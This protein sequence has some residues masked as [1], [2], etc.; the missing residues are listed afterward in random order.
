MNDKH[1]SN[2]QTLAYTNRKGAT[3]YLHEGRTKSGK[4][5][6]FFARSIGEGSLGEL[7]T[8]YEVTETMN[9][10]VSVRRHREDEFAIPDH[11]LALVRGE[12]ERHAHLRHYAA[13]ADRGAI[14]IHQPDV[15]LADL[16]NTA[17]HCLTRGQ[18]ET[19]VADA[20]RRAHFSPVLRLVYDDST[21]V[22]QRMTY[23]GAGGWSYPLSSGP[24]DELVREFVH[25][26]GTDDFFDLM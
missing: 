8:G 13:I 14:V 24:L 18:A 21:Y 5:R 1:S 3:Y 23:R 11:D 7:P 10:V 25:K 17:R 4:P 9:G 12:L 6:Y 22:V 26:L 2:T 15:S 16:R 19:F 20:I